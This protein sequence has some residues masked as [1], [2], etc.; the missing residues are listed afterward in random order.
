MILPRVSRCGPFG[1]DR[2][3]FGKAGC[4]S[5]ALSK[6]VVLLGTMAGTAFVGSMVLG[7]ARRGFLVGRVRTGPVLLRP[8]ADYEPSYRHVDGRQLV[9]LYFGSANCAWSNGD[10]VRRAVR[11]TARSLAE[12]ARR[13]GWSFEAVG[14]A[15]D[16]S[17]DEG[18]K[19]LR[20]VG[21]FDEVS[22]GNSWANMLATRF[23]SGQSGEPAATPE[24]LVVLR[25]LRRPNR[26][27]GVLNHVATRETLVTRKSGLVELTQWAAEG[28]PL[29]PLGNR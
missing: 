24:I 10:Q 23:Y 1:H 28:S 15:L 21:S 13:R 26:A 6:R 29:P 22:A 5:L 4:V 18:L 20:R 2:E 16:W 8:S 11:H 7:A 17:P 27:E 9:M 19:H 25:V 12:Q 14:V 3:A